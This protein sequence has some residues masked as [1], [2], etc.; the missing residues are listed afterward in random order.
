M[1]KKS[2][3]KCF[4]L[5]EKNWSL[6][7]EKNFTSAR[8]RWTNKSEML[9]GFQLTNFYKSFSKNQTF[10]KFKNQFF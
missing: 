2:D 10:L 5:L 8:S 6:I 7:E 1:G 3:L 9:L 4:E